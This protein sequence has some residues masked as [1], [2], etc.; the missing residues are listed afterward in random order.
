MKSAASALGAEIVIAA[1]LSNDVFGHISRA[2]SPARN[3][4]LA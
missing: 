4:N 1:N 3:A 2:D